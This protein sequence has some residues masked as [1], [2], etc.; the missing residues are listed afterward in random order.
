[1]KRPDARLVLTNLAVIAGL[2]VS[3]VR[4]QHSKQ[5]EVKPQVYTFH[6]A[7]D[8]TAACDGALGFANFGDMRDELCDDKGSC[9]WGEGDNFPTIDGYIQTSKT[10]GTYIKD[11]TYRAKSCQ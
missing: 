3:G 4:L 2:S 11:L 9:S 5:P 7:A 1:M 6:Q 8:L 10:K